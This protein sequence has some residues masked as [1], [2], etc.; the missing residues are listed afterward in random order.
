[1]SLSR[2]MSIHPVDVEILYLISENWKEKFRRIYSFG[3]INGF[4]NWQII[5]FLPNSHTF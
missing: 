5:P 1:M 3:I 4:N 2:F